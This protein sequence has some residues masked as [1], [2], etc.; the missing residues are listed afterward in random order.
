MKIATILFVAIML[1]GCSTP[2]KV[3]LPSVGPRAVPAIL[4]GDRPTFTPLTQAEFDAIPIQAKGKILKNQ[5]DWT[6]WA[7]IANAA[8]QGYRGYIG[9]LFNGKK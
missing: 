9:S 3:V 8:I 1:F 4:L 6:A 5:T 7:D 2:A